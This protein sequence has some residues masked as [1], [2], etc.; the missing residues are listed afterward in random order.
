[1]LQ[2]IRK[3]K[4]SSWQIIALGYLA[5]VLIGSL[6][7]S[8]PIAS[9]ARIWTPYIDSIFTATSATCVT[10]LVIY[11]TFTHW[12]IFG[13]VVILSLIQI[14]GIGFMTIIS[15][16]AILTKRQI[17]LYERTILTKSTRTIGVSGVVRLIKRIMVGTFCVELLGAILLSIRF[18]PEMGVVK[19]SYFA[20]F[21]AISAFCNAGFD[22]MGFKGQFSSLTSYNS[23]PLVNITI[24][25]L[26][27]IGGLGF[28]V[29]SDIWDCRFKIKNLTWYTKI[30]LIATSILIVVPTVLFMVF[31]RTN[32]FS[33]MNFGNKLLS[34]LFQSIT[35]RTAGFNTINLRELSD[36]SVLM[37][38]FLMFVGGSSGSTAGGIKVTTLVVILFG[39]KTIVNQNGGITIGKKRLEEGILRQATAIF[40]SYC[41]AIFV[42]ILLLCA[43]E[44]D[45]M[46]YIAFEV[47]SAIGTVGLSM[48]ITPHFSV[49][50]KVI[51]AMLMY[52]G[53][54]G[55]I[56]FVLAFAEKRN[57]PPVQRPI[58]DI[59]IG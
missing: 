15:L 25:M 57:N 13:Q 29:W 30:V 45:S 18:I 28:L 32:V 42:A 54:V 21:H 23:D 5:V 22:L 11:D 19:G 17:G 10:G 36:S 38:M 34:S 51:I 35:P 4:P 16:F 53:R 7:L 47:I 2:K 49:I 26:I 56:T 59:L 27:V 31:E 43:I 3:N 55:L 33:D 6:L 48:G 1:M 58:G 20:V 50:S 12:S 41:I 39:L 52:L 24:M 37:T 44:P 40:S 14:G 46:K 9:K 8:L